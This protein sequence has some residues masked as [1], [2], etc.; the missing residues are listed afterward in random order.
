ML[1]DSQHIMIDVEDYV[2]SAERHLLRSGLMFS[3]TDI[4][5]LIL[6]YMVQYIH[7]AY[8]RYVVTG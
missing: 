3:E 7:V 2:C 6:H 1:T 5:F 8:C 4:K